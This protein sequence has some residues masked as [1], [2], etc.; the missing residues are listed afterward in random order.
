MY[1]MDTRGT[2]PQVYTKKPR[3]PKHIR[4]RAGREVV[5]FQPRKENAFLRN[6]NLNRGHD[7]TSLEGN[8]SKTK[9][10]PLWSRVSPSPPSRGPSNPSPAGRL[11]TPPA[12]LVRRRC[13]LFCPATPRVALLGRR[14]AGASPVA[15][16]RA[17]VPRGVQRLE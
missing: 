3:L 6:G 11:W 5:M 12:C 4:W 9:K 17:G 13:P 10:K 2:H 15:V 14:G 16:G 7:N 8:A 1:E